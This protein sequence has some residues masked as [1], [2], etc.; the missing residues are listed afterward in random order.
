[1]STQG[2]TPE[3]ERSIADSQ[4]FA[5]AAPQ[6]LPSIVSGVSALQSVWEPMPVVFNAVINETGL[7]IRDKI[8]PVRSALPQGFTLQSYSDV[9]RGLIGTGDRFHDHAVR[10]GYQWAIHRNFG[11]EPRIGVRL[12]A[13]SLPV[14]AQVAQVSYAIGHETT[15][16]QLQ[17]DRVIMAGAGLTFHAGI[18]HHRFSAGVDG[19]RVIAAYGDFREQFF[20]QERK[21]QDRNTRPVTVAER[22][23]WLALEGLERWQ[24]T[25]ELSYRYEI[26]PRLELGLSWL[27]RYEH[28]VR[29][30]DLPSDR[31][32]FSI[33][34]IF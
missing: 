10:A 29:N 4:H 15:T 16:F 27:H 30:D 6:L 1:M 18:G 2:P 31:L 34:K 19:D 8:L 5:L 7:P 3:K 33:K 12:F 22:R 32:S 24:F 13:G 9:Y 26:A 23:S 25:S 11:V 21:L 17:A 14:H 20:S 28:F